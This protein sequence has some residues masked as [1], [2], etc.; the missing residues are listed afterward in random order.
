MTTTGC[1][2]IIPFVT[3]CT[4]TS[5]MVPGYILDLSTPVTHDETWEVAWKIV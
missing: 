2:S 4:S 1:L 5:T 3:S